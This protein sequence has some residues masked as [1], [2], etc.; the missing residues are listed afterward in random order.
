MTYLTVGTGGD[1]SD[2]YN[3]VRNGLGQLLVLP[4][5]YTIT[6]IS[7]VTMS[8]SMS[9]G[10]VRG[11]ITYTPMNIVMGGHSITITSNNP[12]KGIVGNGWKTYLTASQSIGFRAD[13][14][15][16][17]S[18]DINVSNLNIQVTGGVGAGAF[19]Y[20]L[21]VRARNKIISDIIIVGKDTDN[22]D[23]GIIEDATY[24]ETTIW[25]NIK[26]HN[27]YYGF[28][29]SSGGS[30]TATV[31][32]KYIENISIYAGH[33]P[34]S[35]DYQSASGGAMEHWHIKNIVA[36]GNAVGFP[37]YDMDASQ[38]TNEMSN[39]ADDD[40]SQPAFA[41]SKQ[42][43]IVLA[44][45][46]VSIDPSSSEFLIPNRTGRIYNAGI[47]PSYATTD[48]AGKPIPY[49]GN[50]PIGCHTAVSRYL[51]RGVGLPFVVEVD[52]IAA[53]RGVG[54]EFSVEV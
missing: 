36:C 23:V 19:R 3:L 52:S 14:A 39:C 49:E 31:R 6:Q 1:Y 20:K 32:D 16:G 47:V 10:V 12:H 42:E 24:R 46:F 27:C 11:G 8:G 48:I 51:G 54:M 37:A 15:G 4:D 17:Y 45:E 26:I 2:W 38:S 30:L 34:F 9:A 29:K 53:G 5:D 13:Y 40:G 43:N 18:G 7:D 33:Y 21:E 50:Y 44:D 35:W 25:K 41:T 28:Y 22:F